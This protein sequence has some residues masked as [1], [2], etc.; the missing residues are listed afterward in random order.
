M[1]TETINQQVHNA[2]RYLIAA[3]S[4]LGFVLDGLQLTDLCFSIALVLWVWQPECDAWES[5]T[6]ISLFKVR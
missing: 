2:N 5:K 6:L 4:I 3:L 1:T